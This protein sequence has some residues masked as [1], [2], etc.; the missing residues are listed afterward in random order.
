[1]MEVEVVEYDRDLFRQPEERCSALY[2]IL[3]GEVQM[4]QKQ[5]TNDGSLKATHHKMVEVTVV[6]LVTTL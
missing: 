6:S 4:V 3:K 1:M 5:I 2:I